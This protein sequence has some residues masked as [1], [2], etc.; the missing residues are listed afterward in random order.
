M[1]RPRGRPKGTGKYTEEIANQILEA[2][3][4]GSSMV[5]AAKPFGLNESTVRGWRDQHE[6]FSA[7]YTR[8]MQNRADTFFERGCR[9][10][11]GI[12]SGEES[13]IARVQLDWLKWAACKMYPRIYGDR[14]AITGADGGDPTIKLVC[15]IPRPTGDTEKG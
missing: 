5:E 6:D 9:I 10:A 8:A 15:S 7:K 4:N 3:S 2:V 11:F 13:Q 14:Q 1:A 12:K